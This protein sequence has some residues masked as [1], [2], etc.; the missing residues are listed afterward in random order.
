MKKIFVFLVYLI[1]LPVGLYVPK[2]EAENTERLIQTDEGKAD[3]SGTYSFDQA[4]TA[5]GFRVEHLGL[6]EIPGYFRD[7]NGTIKY[8]AKDIEIFSMEP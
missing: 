1:F 8:D 6:V 7:F 4:H 5:I 2:A 3:F